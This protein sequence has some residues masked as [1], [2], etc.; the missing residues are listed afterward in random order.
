VELGRRRTFTH[1]RDNAYVE[2]ARYPEAAVAYHEAFT[3]ELATNCGFREVT[4]GPQGGAQ[5]E[6]VA[7]KPGAASRPHSGRS[8]DEEEPGR[9][10]AP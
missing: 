6:L 9:V 3:I 2:S 7:R 5:S 1:R 8:A 10:D 4:V